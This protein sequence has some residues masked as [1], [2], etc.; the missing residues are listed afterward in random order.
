MDKSK[1]QL[2]IEILCALMSKGPLKWRQISNDVE[3]S[4]PNLIEQLDYLYERGL[5]GVSNL[6]DT[7]KSYFV[8]ERG[9]SVIKVIGPMVRE[10]QR[11]EVQNLERISRALSST[12]FK[13][14]KAEEKKPV[15]KRLQDIIK[16]DV[17]QTEE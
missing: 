10:A 9:L 5:V 15:W 6:D 4:K 16:I 11:L 1:L 7:E 12:K 8:T 17:L 13:V 14:R 3:L 2:S